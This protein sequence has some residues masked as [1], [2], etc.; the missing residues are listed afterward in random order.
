MAITPGSLRNQTALITGA[1]RGIGKAICLALDSLGAMLLIHYHQNRAAAE[2]LAA[3][4]TQPQ[5]RIL[6]AD[7]AAAGSISGMID[8]LEDD[9]VDILV[10][11]AGIW[12]PTP[13]GTTTEQRVDEVLDTNLKGMF[14]LTQA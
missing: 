1:S 11:N 5:P 3:T 9:S 7:L 6:Q 8:L 2:Q 10:N 4:L 13:L 14:W 12:K